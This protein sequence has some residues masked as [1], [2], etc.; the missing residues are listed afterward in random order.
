M[1][2]IKQPSVP[3]TTFPNF[4]KLPGELR[5]M[6]WGYA[7][8]EAR[9]AGL[10]SEPA[11]L[12]LQR[13]KRAHF[14][15]IFDTQNE[16]HLVPQDQHLHDQS[17]VL[18]CYTLAAPRIDA[19]SRGSWLEANTNAFISQWSVCAESRAFAAYHLKEVKQPIPFG[20]PS[21]G[22]PPI[23]DTCNDTCIPQ[24]LSEWKILSSSIWQGIGKNEDQGI[25]KNEDTMKRKMARWGVSRNHVEKY[26]GRFSMNGETHTFTVLK[27]LDLICLRP[28]NM[29]TFNWF[30]AQSAFLQLKTHNTAFEMRSG[31]TAPGNG[32]LE[33]WESLVMRILAQIR[34]G[35]GRSEGLRSFWIIDYRI[36]PKQGAV[37][38]VTNSRR[39]RK[40]PIRFEGRG[41]DYVEVIYEEESLWEFEGLEGETRSLRFLRIWNIGT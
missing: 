20:L 13:G 10:H 37:R 39:R 27:D 23:L 28:L 6:I 35:R 24:H 2:I 38:P 9:K 26:V 36:H 31:W 5:N 19:S 4:T 29:A 33:S 30:P 21:S 3:A 16:A 11:A 17:S 7:L 25:G 18:R 41:C 14:F 15:T 40:D 1:E 12:W 32:T 8:H 22:G 34:G